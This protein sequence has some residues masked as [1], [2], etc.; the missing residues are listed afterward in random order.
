[1]QREMDIPP[2][3]IPAPDPISVGRAIRPED[4]DFPAFSGFTDMDPRSSRMISMKEELLTFDDLDTSQYMGIVEPNPANLQAIRGLVHIPLA[5]WGTHLIPATDARKAV[6]GF[7]NFLK[8][9]TLIKPLIDP[10]INLDSPRLF[11]YPFIYITADQSFDLTEMEKKNLGSY[12]RNGGFALIEAYGEV[13]RDPAA[14]G[15]FLFQ[16]SYGFATGGGSTMISPM[17]VRDDSALGGEKTPI[18]RTGMK[19]PPSTWTKRDRRRQ[20]RKSLRLSRSNFLKSMR[21][22]NFKTGIWEGD[23]TM[24]HLLTAGKPNGL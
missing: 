22:E 10:P 15:T 2:F 13:S 9:Y 6:D 5:V 21:S 23:S 8:S 14:A 17:I 18:L 1:I 3:R 11:E 12:L 20:K 19:I 4:P 16:V 7:T 24:S